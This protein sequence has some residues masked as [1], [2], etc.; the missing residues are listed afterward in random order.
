MGNRAVIIAQNKEGKVSNVGLYLHWN[1]GFNSIQ[2]FLAYCEMMDFRPPEMDS[3]GWAQM[4]KI[5]GNFFDEGKRSNGLSL[6]VISVADAK[7]KNGQLADDAVAKLTPG[8]NGVY[9]IRDWHVVQHLDGWYP[10]EAT[11]A[12]ELEEF[13]IEI[14]SA[15][16][17]QVPEEE[18]YEFAEKY[19]SEESTGSAA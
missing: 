6:G 5:I 16:P 14:N 18:I 19:E 11:S 10:D 15:Q 9:I 13:M 12:E 17:Y 3:Y 2:A 7:T 1:G 8:D 4:V